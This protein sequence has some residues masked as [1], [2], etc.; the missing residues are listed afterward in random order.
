[1]LTT[2]LTGRNPGFS[3]AENIDDL[4]VGKTLLHGD[5]LM[6]LMKTLLTS[7]CTNQWGAGQGTVQADRSYAQH[8]N[9]VPSSLGIHGKPGLR[10][11]PQ[12][13]THTQIAYSGQQSVSISPV[14]DD[15]GED[16]R[17]NY[18]KWY[19]DAQS[20]CDKLPSCIVTN[21]PQIWLHYQ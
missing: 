15:E 21:H 9:W 6:W 20:M 18:D 1:M 12:V 8:K 3:L 16:G 11:T 14:N 19:S 7:G 4:F 13:Q 5:V 17:I 2:E 10:E